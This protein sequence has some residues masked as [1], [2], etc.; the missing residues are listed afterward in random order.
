MFLNAFGV[1][2]EWFTQTEARPQPADLFWLAL[3]P[4]MIAGLAS[5]VYWRIGGED[6]G[7]MAM[8]TAATVVST[9]FLGIFAWQFL[10]WQTPRDP[11]NLAAW[12]IVIA[13]PLFD[14]MVIPL[15]LGLF[16]TGAAR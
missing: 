9:V 13:Y 15:I 4:F 1:T 10:V 7:T 14:L 12:A 5:L 2:V 8:N 6:K 3:Y 16:M 11:T